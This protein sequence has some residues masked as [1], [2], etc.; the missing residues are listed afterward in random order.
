[1]GVESPLQISC[2]YICMLTKAES[3]LQNQNSQV[4]VAEIRF[5]DANHTSTHILPHIFQTVVE[6][7]FLNRPVFTMYSSK[8]A[9]G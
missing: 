2:M 3:A 5:C 1:M 4:Q 8:T 7:R 9:R 6:N